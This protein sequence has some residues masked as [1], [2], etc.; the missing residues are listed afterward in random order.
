M[1]SCRRLQPVEQLVTFWTFSFLLDRLLAMLSNPKDSVPKI[2]E[3][4]MYA[5]PMVGV[6][7][8]GFNDDTTMEL[9]TRQQAL[10]AFYA[11]SRNHNDI[12]MVDQGP[13]AMGGKEPG[14][15]TI[16][17]VVS[18]YVLLSDKNK[19]SGEVF[20]E[21]RESID[22]IENGR[23]Y[24]ARVN[25]INNRLALGSVNSTKIREII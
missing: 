13:A 14:L 7:I 19:S 3:F 5:I 4:S 15:A 20:I 11:F 10:G 1:S 17:F 16:D 9:C 8:C 6:N 22:S 18:L 2:L 24:L 21:D 23:Y 25:A 12:N